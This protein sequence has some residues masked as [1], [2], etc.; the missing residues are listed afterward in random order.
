MS[1]DLKIKM[2]KRPTYFINETDKDIRIMM[3]QNGY[4]RVDKV[5]DAD[6]VLFTGG[7]DVCPLLYGETKHPRTNASLLRDRRDINLLRRCK[8]PQEQVKVGICRGAQFLNVMVGNGTL[9]QHVDKHDK[10]YH[11]A[12]DNQGSIIRV[13]STHHQVMQPG[14][15]GKT[16]LHS[17]ESTKMEADSWE[18]ELDKAEDCD[19]PEVVLYLEQN[20]LCFQPHPEIRET[21]NNACCK[22]FFDL[23]DEYFLNKSQSE[24][25]AAHKKT[26]S[27]FTSSKKKVS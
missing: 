10:G 1:S 5:G 8:S 12:I 11:D 2:D 7:P 15:D 24:A 6:F 3:G 19:Q 18:W 9:W 13:S 14:I 25:V 23:L 17:F 22:L 27:H 20:T 26:M 16:L 4:R 21:E